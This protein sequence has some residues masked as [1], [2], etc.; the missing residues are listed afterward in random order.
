MTD[1]S[2]FQIVI[3]FL[4]MDALIISLVM[5]IFFMAIKR[6]NSSSDFPKIVE[7]W[8]AYSKPEGKRFS[9]QYIALNQIWFKNAANL[10]IADEGLYL[11]FGFPISLTIKDAACIPWNYLTYRKKT[12]YLWTD[13]YEY[14]IQLDT[15]VI[16]TVMARVAR[17][18][19][20][21]QKPIE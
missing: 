17:A 6:F 5:W 8:P 9:R 13:M 18:F 1:E 20:E 10:V 21:L 12:R 11:S 7:R 15:P 14:E 2:L 16:L 19:P 3:L 4:I